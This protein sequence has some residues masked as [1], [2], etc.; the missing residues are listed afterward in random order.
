M[1]GVTLFLAGFRKTKQ[2]TEDE[3]SNGNIW[4]QVMVG[5]VTIIAIINVGEFGISI[6]VSI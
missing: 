6:K 5:L 3:A 4:N 1:A 2:I